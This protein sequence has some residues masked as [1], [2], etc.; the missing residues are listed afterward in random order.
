MQVLSDEDNAGETASRTPAKPFDA[1]YT[2]VHQRLMIK[3]ANETALAIE[4][5]NRSSPEPCASTHLL[6]LTNGN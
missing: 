5:G 4:E 2:M 3:A 6:V 1:R